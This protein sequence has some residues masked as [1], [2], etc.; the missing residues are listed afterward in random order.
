MRSFQIEIRKRTIFSGDNTDLSDLLKA[1]LMHG[2]M[3]NF[4]EIREKLHNMWHRKE[5]NGQQHIGWEIA[6]F[7]N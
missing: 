2:H 7:I 3:F 6:C 4:I 5:K 1:C